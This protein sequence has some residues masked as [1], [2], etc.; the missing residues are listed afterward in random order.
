MRLK[1]HLARACSELGLAFD[2]DYVVV[3][4]SGRTVRA[5]GRVRSIGGTEGTLIFSKYED[6]RS[7]R[8]EVSDLRDSGAFLLDVYIEMFSE[9]A[10]AGRE[11]DRP[12]WIQEYA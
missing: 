7:S 2:L 9:W 5:I 8:D 6:V 11:E 3:V 1:E 4:P 10:W 12:S